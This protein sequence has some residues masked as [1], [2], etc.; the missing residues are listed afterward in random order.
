[1]RD[2]ETLDPKQAPCLYCNSRMPTRYPRVASD[3]SGQRRKD[4]D[5][6]IS[7]IESGA[8]TSRGLARASGVE[9]STRNLIIP[10]SD[11]NFIMIQLT[12]IQPC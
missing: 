4:I 6:L 8:C 9:L 12:V 7:L 2:A 1:M 5:S 11:T 10:R 3:M